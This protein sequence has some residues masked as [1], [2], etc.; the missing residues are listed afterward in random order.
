METIVKKILVHML[1]FG[2]VLLY[3]ENKSSDTSK[4]FVTNA[5]IS[6]SARFYDGIG[7][8]HHTPSHFAKSFFD[9]LPQPCALKQR[10]YLSNTRVCRRSARTLNLQHNVLISTPT[11]LSI[12]PQHFVSCP[13]H[14]HNRHLVICHNIVGNGSTKFLL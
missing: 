9:F 7:N 8:I 12:H 6:I 11:A 10:A 5:V 4:T 3:I 2:S 14:M 1:L 13:N